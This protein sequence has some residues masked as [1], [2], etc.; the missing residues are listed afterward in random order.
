MPLAVMERTEP[1]AYKPTRQKYA[2]PTTDRQDDVCT[3]RG[4]Q[5]AEG[6]EIMCYP[7]KMG[8]PALAINSKHD[9]L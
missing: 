1:Y 9:M 3:G 2:T 6:H 8:K 4:D 5:D 7:S